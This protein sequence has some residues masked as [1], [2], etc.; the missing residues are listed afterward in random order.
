MSDNVILRMQDIVKEFSGT[1]VLDEVDF[2]VRGGEVHGLIGENGAGKSTLMNVLAGRFDDYGGLIEFDG[3]DV[4][5]SNPRQ[6]RDMGIAVIYQELSVLPNFTVAENIMLGDEKARHWTRKMDRASINAGACKAIEYLRF[7][8][9]PD[10]PVGRLSKA[11]QCLVEIAGA[12]RRNVKLLVFDEPTASLGSEDIDKLFQVIKDLRSRG[13]AIV[14]IS[15]RLGELPLI[16]DRVTVLRDGKVVGT[17]SITECEISDLTHMMLGHD[18][19]EVFPEKTNQPGKTILK[20]DGL[21]SPGVFEN[22]CFELR[23]GE[24]LGIAGL[25]G[26]GRTEIVRAIFA[27]GNASGRVEFRGK[28]IPVRSPYMCCALGIGMVPENRKLEGNITGRPICENLNISI[29]ERLAGTLGFQSPQRLADRAECMIERMGV[30]PPELEME[31]QNLSGGNQQ[32]VV[33]GRWLA[34]ESNVI[35]FDEPTQGIDVGTKSQMYRLIMD[36]AC[37]GKAIILISSDLIEITKLADRILVIRNGRLVR[38]M[39]AAET[40]EDVLFA[41]CAGKD[42]FE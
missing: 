2:D 24:I 19:G 37:Q 7:D 13:L 33:V 27:T 22:I 38:E 1:R 5:I 30:D 11:K 26:S 23:E 39:P 16:A 12:V 18:L 20:V 40:R 4:R 25:V 42:K 28:P 35:I 29:L 10:E 6:A 31:I 3:R 41:E 32:K 9:D 36:L 15:H 14:Y 34:A 17:K 8:L 21:S